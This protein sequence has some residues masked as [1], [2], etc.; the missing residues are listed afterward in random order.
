MP[1]SVTPKTDCPHTL[2]NVICD[3]E[4]LKGTLNKEC[5]EC[6]ATGENWV[7]LKCHLVGC[8]RYVCGHLATHA[9]DEEHCIALSFSD[10]SVWCYQCS[11]YIIHEEIKPIIS[12]Y[13]QEKFNC[14]PGE[15]KMVTEEDI[16][17]I[18][19]FSN[20]MGLDFQNIIDKNDLDVE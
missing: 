19:E 12:Q 18:A 1:Y 10:L 9:E 11:S 6:N 4:K 13:H 8:S 5:Y 16:E 3:L 20:Q 2:D 17:Y 7:C 14:L 15:S